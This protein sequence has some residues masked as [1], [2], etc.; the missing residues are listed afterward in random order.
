M[1]WSL[2]FGQVAMNGWRIFNDIYIV[3]SD[4]KIVD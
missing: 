2:V 3:A 4:Y 1:V